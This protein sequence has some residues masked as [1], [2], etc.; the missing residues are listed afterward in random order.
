MDR[1]EHWRYR[2]EVFQ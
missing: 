2:C 1:D